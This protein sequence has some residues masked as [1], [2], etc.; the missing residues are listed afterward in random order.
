MAAGACLSWKSV[1]LGAGMSLCPAARALGFYGSVCLL[2]WLFG[3]GL[4][5]TG[6]LRVPPLPKLVLAA[7]RARSPALPSTPGVC[8]LKSPKLQMHGHMVISS[9]WFFFQKPLCCSNML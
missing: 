7:P 9:S 3:E 5:E 8:S 4:I 2:G 6:G 1:W